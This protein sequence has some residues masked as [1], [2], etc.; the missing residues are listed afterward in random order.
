MSILVA[1][2][3]TNKHMDIAFSEYVGLILCFMGLFAVQLAK[4]KVP[5]ST[6]SVGALVAKPYK[7]F[8]LVM[9]PLRWDWTLI[10]KC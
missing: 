2:L 1:L 3:I 10:G 5:L 8:R 6:C 4:P 9:F 7:H